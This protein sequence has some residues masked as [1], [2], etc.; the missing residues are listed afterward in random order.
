VDITVYLPDEIGEHAKQRKLNLSRLLRN[1]VIT[2]LE[3]MDT[4]ETTLQTSQEYQLDLEDEDGRAYTGRIVG[5][6]IAWDEREETS[7]YLTSDERVIAYD[8]RRL[9]YWELGDPAE[10]LRQLGPIVYTQACNALG[11]RAVIDL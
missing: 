4:V 1:A 11:I 6:E 7:V 10:D 5:K 2:E 8:G 3:R 9:R